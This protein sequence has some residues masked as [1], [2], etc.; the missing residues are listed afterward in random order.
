MGLQWEAQKEI[1]RIH[2]DVI[3]KAIKDAEGTAVTYVLMNISDLK[4]ISD[5]MDFFAYD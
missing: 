1:Q 4:K 5:F 2:Q 3:E